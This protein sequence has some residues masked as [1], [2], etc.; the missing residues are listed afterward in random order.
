M[1]SKLKAII[2][3]IDDVLY[4]A[5]LQSSN[6]RL[7]AVKAMIER[8][9]KRRDVVLEALDNLPGIKVYPPGGA[10]YAWIDITGTGM[11]SEK[12]SS[13]L[14]AE[15]KVGVMPGP[16]FGKQGEGH[17]R[18]SFATPE[19]KLKVGLERFRDFVMDHTA[20]M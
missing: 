18:I 8:F 17:V 1:S 4:D 3:G 13:K 14:L 19:D 15:Q 7:S 6:A 2:F 5:T 10:F 16:L 11:S 20:N 9:K 12:F